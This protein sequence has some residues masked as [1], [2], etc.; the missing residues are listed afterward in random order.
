TTNRQKALRAVAGRCDTLVVIGSANSSNTLALVRTAR[1]AGC[2]RA[3]RVNR[4]SEL[5]DDLAGVVGVIA[6][7]SAPESLVEEVLARLAPTNGTEEV[8]AVAEDEYFPLPRELRE[9]LRS[10]ANLLSVAAFA[11]VA[12]AAGPSPDRAQLDGRD[13]LAAEVLAALG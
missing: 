1:A 7:A 6:G 2:P 3:L 9:V 12:D 11:P 8:H 5:P 4:A 10:V 13:V